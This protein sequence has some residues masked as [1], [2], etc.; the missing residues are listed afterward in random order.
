[1]PG[2]EA[3]AEHIYRQAIAAGQLEALNSLG[4][5]L[6]ERGHAK[7]AEEVFWEAVDADVEDAAFNLAS[8]LAQQ[9]GRLREAETLYRQ[10]MEAGD[11][12]AANNLAVLVLVRGGETAEAERL[13]QLAASL[14]D[15]F[16]GSNLRVLRA[17]RLIGSQHRLLTDSAV[18]EGD[19]DMKL[20]F[21]TAA[22][23]Q[24]PPLKEL[25]AVPLFGQ[26]AATQGFALTA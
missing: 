16:A 3:D 8:L 17:S 20:G 23:R 6:A 14:G 25:I 13:F 2:R 22:P 10:A 5:Y 9:A 21:Q 1:M 4:V 7:E 26:P 19:I 24:P 12:N 11:P 18:T 15:P